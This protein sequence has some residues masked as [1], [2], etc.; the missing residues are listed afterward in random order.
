MNRLQVPIVPL[1]SPVRARV[2]DPEYP[3]FT[4]ILMRYRWKPSV[5]A[6]V[7]RIYSPL[8][9]KMRGAGG[10][11]Q[12][13]TKTSNRLGKRKI[14]TSNKGI[15]LM[16]VIKQR[17]FDGELFLNLEGKREVLLGSPYIEHFVWSF[18]FKIRKYGNC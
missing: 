14:L 5:Y 9:A 1:P 8:K 16:D 6:A 12:R 10:C 2:K 18:T 11:Y 13:F 15:E 17:G 3:Q 7:Q 4:P